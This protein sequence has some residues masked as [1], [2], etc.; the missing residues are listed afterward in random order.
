MD[1]MAQWM[2]LVIDGVSKGQWT[3]E[4]PDHMVEY[5]SPDA[6]KRQSGSYA[7]K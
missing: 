3:N 1:A 2:A 5:A 7:E 6:P 4:V